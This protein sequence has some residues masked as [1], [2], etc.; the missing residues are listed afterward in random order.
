MQRLGV[1]PDSV[2]VLTAERV[3]WRSGA[4]GCPEPGMNYSMALV[5]GTLIILNAGRKQYRYHAGKDGKPFHCP[6]ER[7][8]AP[9]YDQDSEMT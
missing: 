7:V 2:S 3:Q 6:P 4:L 5:P 1:G 9:I 8:E